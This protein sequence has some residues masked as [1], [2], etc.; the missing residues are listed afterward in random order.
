MVDSKIQAEAALLI[1][2]KAEVAA[3]HLLDRTLEKMMP[4]K[5]TKFKYM[6]LRVLRVSC[7]S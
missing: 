2:L 4:S 3:A 5:V 6:Q 7:K 1:R